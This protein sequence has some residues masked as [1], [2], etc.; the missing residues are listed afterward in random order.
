MK[1]ILI[2]KGNNKRITQHLCISKPLYMARIQSTPMIAT[3]TIVIGV[4]ALLGFYL[5]FTLAK[6]MIRIALLVAIIVII[7]VA[8]KIT[9][10]DIPYIPFV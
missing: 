2:S 1:R 6:D 4:L 8:L 3:S 10:G 7:L 9:Q 5:A